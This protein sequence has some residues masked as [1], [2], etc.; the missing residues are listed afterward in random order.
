[1]QKQRKKTQKERKK[2]EREEEE[3][4]EEEEGDQL[5]TQ[6]GAATQVAPR[7]TTVSGLSFFSDLQ[8]FFFFFSFFFFFFISAFSSAVSA[9][10]LID[11]LFL[12]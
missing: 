5:K 4:E 6:A 10:W 1:M 8:L 3:E 12:G 9:F 2:K 7:P 11:V